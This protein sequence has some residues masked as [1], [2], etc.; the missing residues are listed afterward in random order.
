MGKTD[1]ENSRYTEAAEETLRRSALLAG[2]R[3]HTYVGTEHILLSLTKAGAAQ[4]VLERHGIGYDGVSAEI[5]DLI[6]RGTPC[7]TDDS[8]FTLNVCRALSDASADKGIS[9][10]IGTEHILSALMGLKDCCAQRIVRRLGA[11]PSH[12]SA[13]CSCG[14]MRSR[15]QPRLKAL[16]RFGRELTEPS[17]CIGFDPLIGREE[18]LRRVMEILCRRSKN[19]PCLVGDAGVG[20]TA[21]A[22]GL[23]VKIM[24]GSVPPKLADM[25]IFSLDITLLLAGAKYRG[26]FEERL[27]VC[28]EEAENSGNVIL[29]I[30]EVHNIM[31]AGA[32][33]GAIDAAN[34]LKPRLARGK[35]RIIGATTFEEYRRTIER[36][37][38]MDR[39]FSKVVISE[40]DEHQTLRILM[41]L[42]DRFEEYHGINVPKETCEYAVKLSGRYIRDRHFPDKAIDLLDEACSAAGVDA[43]DSRALGEKAFERYISGEIARAEYL[44]LICSGR[45]RRTLTCDMLE[46]A[47]S[48]ITGMNCSAADDS[49]RLLLSGMEERLSARVIGQHK[50]VSEVCRAVRR[51]RMGL[52]GGKRPLG[53]FVFAGCTGVGKTLLATELARELTG[54][55]DGLIRLDMSEYMEP[56][57]VSK[58]IGSPPGYVGCEDGGRLVEL[59]RRSPC[60]V[61]L[62]DEIEKAHHDI[63][64]ILLQML[65]EGVLTDSL[66]RSASLSELTVI[67]TTNAGAA[68]LSEH[69]CTGFND[70]SSQRS[71]DM[72]KAVRRILSPE[73]IG[74]MDSIIVFETLGRQALCKVAELEVQKLISRA[75]QAGCELKASPEFAAYAAD[76]CL[77]HEGSAREVRRIVTHEAEDALCDKL[78]EGASGE[79]CLC[80]RDGAPRIIE[81]AAA[82]T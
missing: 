53:S 69:R 74:R 55:D 81:S 10:S 64:G 26:D 25:R 27:K 50:A 57:S 34:I 43:N 9:G 56:H 37:A 62:F 22:E 47:A 12:I 15:S 77:A 1:K 41:G 30:D 61:L 51:R 24:S 54:T 29:F 48:R 2:Q 13:D 71:G 76:K 32:A 44:D 39:R 78:M 20:K 6:G 23:A 80:I 4:A 3:G 40:P 21:I 60:G 35:L 19:D 45:K 28:L 31:G 8:A 17:V 66:G 63:F 73:L 59:I 67:L 5:D 52:R 38:A 36:D 18:E 11:E 79:L 68:Q 72:E 14:D 46:R 75:S 82:K 58:L 7:V 49:E 33:E 70:K 65:E 42:K 16:S